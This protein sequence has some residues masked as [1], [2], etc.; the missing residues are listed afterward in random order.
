MKWMK[1]DCDANRSPKLEKLLMVHGVAGFG[2]YWLIVELIGDPIDKGNISFTL[3]HDTSILA[4]RGKLEESQVIEMLDWMIAETLFERN[5]STGDITCWKL[6]ERIDTS[7]VRNP[8]LKQIQQRIRAEILINPETLAD[9]PNDSEQYLLDVDSDLDSDSENSSA[10]AMTLQ[11]QPG[12]RI[13]A[14]LKYHHSVDEDFA[15]QY[16]PSFQSYWIKK[17]AKRLDWDSKFYDQC[18][19]QFKRKGKRG[20]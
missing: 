10:A 1:H 13:L 7:L 19:E 3:K 9:I 16:L 8:Q 18:A 12:D 14:D 4:H 6:A 11:W 15:E 20:G 17:K 5:P 2:L